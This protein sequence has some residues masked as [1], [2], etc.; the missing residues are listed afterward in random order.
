MNEIKC[1]IY[2]RYSSN[3]QREASIEDQIRKCKELAKSKGWTVLENHI[4][5][6]KAQS[7][8]QIDSRINFKKMLRVAMSENCPFKKIIVDDTSRIARNTKEALNI[9]SLLNF[10]GIHIYYVAQGIDTADETAEEMITI[11][12]LIDSIYIRNLAK[13]THRG[14][15]G[16]VLKGFSA[17]GK[18]YGYYSIP[19]YNGKVDIY[20]NPLA[21][22]YILKIN[23]EE[24]E[25]VIR[26]FRL[27]GEEGYSARKIVNILNKELRENGKPKPPRGNFWTVSTIIGSKKSLRGILNNEIYIGIYRWNRTSYKRNPENGSKKRIQK[28]SHK[29]IT[30]HKPELRIVSDEL[31]KKVKKRQRH[32]HESTNGKYV[33]AKKLYSKNLFTG[34]M[35]CGLCKGNF[36]VVS[37]GRY[38]KYGCSNNWNK[39]DSVCVNDLKIEKNKLE[40][41][42]FHALNLDFTKEEY[43]DYVFSR[44]NSITQS[45]MMED[46]DIWMVESLEDHL[47]KIKKEIENYINAIKF[48]IITETVKDQLINAEKKREEIENKLKNINNQ[49]IKPPE[50]THQEISNYL[51]NLHS[52]LSLHTVLGREILSE[53]ID[54]IVITPFEDRI[55]IEISFNAENV[56]K[57]NQVKL[58]F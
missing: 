58:T 13:E 32:I 21:D 50:I 51:K 12:G 3:N 10:Y 30:T 55:T 23:P 41:A 49:Y 46:Q 40:S 9:F 38:A 43:V 7:G 34:L 22:G 25:T 37:G 11:N 2:A 1:A 15:E 33:K 52:T 14:I 42:I 8:T 20:G 6:D 17:G 29:W 56:F 47:K 48:G 27:F 45:K 4:Y 31:W 19:V 39:G 35:A 54:K 36:V 16:Q 53:I 5:F 26:I 24:A 44:V 28:E 18:R 57:K